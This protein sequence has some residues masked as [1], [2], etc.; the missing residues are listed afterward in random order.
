MPLRRLLEESAFEP[1]SVERLA[2][3]FDAACLELGLAQ[4]PNDP[5]REM[6][7]RQ[8]IEVAK[9]GERDP[10]RLCDLAL[11]AIRG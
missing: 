10:Q 8:I 3:A 7:A 9:L 6:V 5:L 2:E 4:R 1:E 11:A